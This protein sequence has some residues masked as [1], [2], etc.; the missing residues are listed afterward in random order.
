MAYIRY[1]IYPDNPSA[2]ET[3][4]SKAYGKFY[5]GLVVVWGSVGA[6]IY[7]I[8]SLVSAINNAIYENL[9]YSVLVLLAMSVVDFLS[10]FWGV[11]KAT[12]RLAAKKFYAFFFCGM[13]SVGAITSII[14]SILDRNTDSL[15]FMASII[16]LL[17]AV[18]AV[19]LFCRIIN[20]R[21]KVRLFT[22]RKSLN[23]L[24]LQQQTAEDEVS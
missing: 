23:K 12:K 17:I 9:F 2:T 15:L 20:R 11:N 3:E 22:D 7:F 1:K 10:I 4:R 24:I 19:C 5:L 13:I 6:I 14:V 16:V 21:P 18:A 8:C